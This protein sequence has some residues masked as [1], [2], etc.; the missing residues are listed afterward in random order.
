MYGALLVTKTCDVDFCRT[1][2]HDNGIA[3][4]TDGDRIGS[5]RCG[6]QSGLTRESLIV[7]T[8]GSNDLSRKDAQSKW[9][10]CKS[11]I[12]YSLSRI[13]LAKVNASRCSVPAVAK[14]GS[15]T[16]KLVFQPAALATDSDS[17]GHFARIGKK[18]PWLA[19]GGQ[20]A[21][22]RT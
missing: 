12:R 17:L 5:L 15:E 8:C 14:A 18:T 1:C 7:F 22:T 20:N 10:E 11:H 6:T 13:L 2:D 4:N 16:L 9:Q 3:A 19:F 21:K